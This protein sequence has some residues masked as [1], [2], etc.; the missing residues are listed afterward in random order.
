V[1]FGSTYGKT[2]PLI[3]GMAGFKVKLLDKFAMMPS[4]DVVTDTSAN[5]AIYQ[6]S[7]GLMF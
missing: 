4:I 3:G 7:L 6:A 1:S 2:E 5:A